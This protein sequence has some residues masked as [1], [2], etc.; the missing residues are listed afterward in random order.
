MEQYKYLGWE[1]FGVEHLTENYGN[2]VKTK[3]TAW[4]GYAIEANGWR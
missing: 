1:D 3:F 2:S 4:F